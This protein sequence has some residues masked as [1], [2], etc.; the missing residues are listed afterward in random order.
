MDE[1]QA[2]PFPL[3]LDGVVIVV[4]CLVGDTDEVGSR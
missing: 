4:L 3:S 1:S 2:G